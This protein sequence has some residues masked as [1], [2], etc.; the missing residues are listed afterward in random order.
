MI[1]ELYQLSNALDA[2]KIQMSTWHR[3]YLPLPKANEKKPCVRILL[4]GDGTVSLSRIPDK[5]AAFLRKYG[6]NQGSF[7]AMNLAPL[8]RITNTEQKKLLQS[9]LQ[10]KRA[11]PSLDIIQQWATEPN[12]S[13]KFLRKYTNSL[14]TVPTEIKKTLSEFAELAIFQLIQ[15]TEPL[16]DPKCLH[17]MLWK[18]AFSM[19]E[20]QVDT[21]L[22]LQV[23]F[24]PGDEKKTARDDFGTLSVVLDSRML[25]RQ[26]TPAIGPVFMQQFNAAMLQAEQERMVASDISSME[27]DAFGQSFSPSDD[28]MP[29]VKLAGGFETALRTMFHA[30]PCQYRYGRIENDTYPLSLEIRTQLKN[31]LEWV[32][33]EDHRNI[34]WMNLSR[35]DILF[36]YPDRLPKLSGSFVRLFGTSANTS[37]KVLFEQEAQNFL[38]LFKPQENGTEVHPERIQL[39]V[40]RKVDRGRNKVVY[41]LN[42]TPADVQRRSVQWIEGCQ[43]HP[44][45]RLKTPPVPYPAQAAETLNLAWKQDGTIFPNNSQHFPLYHGI[46]LF[47]GTEHAPTLELHVLVQNTLG[48]AGCAGRLMCLPKEQWTS[49]KSQLWGIRQA[50]T[51]FALLLYQMG[52]RKETY[53]QNFPYL[54]GQLLKTSDELHVLYCRV[55][56]NDEIPP[57]L[58]GSSCYTAAAE[59]PVRTLAQLGQRM[60]PYLNWA[61]SYQYKSVQTKGCESWRA[62]WLLGVYEKIVAALSSVWTPAIHFTDEEK[63]QLFMGYLA[64][65]PKTAKIPDGNEIKNDEEESEDVE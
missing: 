13:D 48:L 17:Q 6:S 21:I 64:R 25:E 9:V 57:Q 29:R 11:A 52:I 37:G 4:N 34:T 60:A 43:N 30:H 56:R 63:A 14:K 26:G 24:Y 2:A 45:F 39:F 49:Y 31:A 54:Y 50:T 59:A 23:L 62:M 35:S 32:S 22:A 41:T 18:A 38:A 42:T 44:S 27:M 65:L 3:K 1:N 47:F 40:L 28:P 16:Q 46:R 36:A 19:L 8:Y 15:E 10:S 12:W 55:V 20:R 5:D 58:A 33:D 53:M 51:L 7:P 61:R